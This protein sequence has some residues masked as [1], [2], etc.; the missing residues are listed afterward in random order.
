M[1]SPRRWLRRIADAAFGTPFERALAHGRRNPG[2]GVLMLWNRGLGDIA[3]GVVP[4]ML[5][6]RDALPEAPITVLTRA[7]LAAPF[8]LTPASRVIP[9][10]GLQRGASMDLEAACERVGIDAKAFG[11]VLAA[12]DPSRWL[13]HG[14]DPRPTRLSWRPEWDALAAPLLPA[15]AA[16]LVAAHVSSETARH[17]GY[18]KD[19]PAERWRALLAEFP[20][21]SGVHW[22]LLG[23]SGEEAF[24]GDNVTDLRGRTDFPALMAVIR[25]SRVL[26]GPDSGVLSCAYFIADPRPLAV[27]SLWADPRQGVLKRGEPSPNPSLVHVPIL[28]PGEDMARLAVAPVAA[29]LRGALG[30]IG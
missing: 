28:A 5:A 22:V 9:V 8:A 2:E 12:P 26:L 17:Y 24:P 25:R 27:I 14:R 7:D 15:T 10:P 13:A 19:W 3:L 18:V 11:V 20:A 16:T 29:A 6:A 1:P 4:L 30:S 21:G 23:L